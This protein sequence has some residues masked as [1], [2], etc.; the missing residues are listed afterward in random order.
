VCFLDWA[1]CCLQWT[2]ELQSIATGEAAT[3]FLVFKECE[4]NTLNVLYGCVSSETAAT[5]L[6]STISSCFA[7]EVSSSEA[8]VKR[9]A[10]NWPRVL[11]FARRACD[12][13]K[14]ADVKGSERAVLVA[15]L[16]SGLCSP[17]VA[18][19]PQIIVCI[20]TLARFLCGCGRNA[21][22]VDD[23]ERGYREY[24]KWLGQVIAGAS[25]PFVQSLCTC[26]ISL[27]PHEPARY[28]RANEKVLFRAPGLR[29]V[30][31]DYVALARTR[32]F[33]LESS[34][35]TADLAGQATKVVKC[36]AS[37][38]IAEV[39]RFV[40][41]FAIGG[42]V[43]PVSLVRQMNFHRHN[44]R[45]V[46]LEPLLAPDLMPP[47]SFL[48]ELFPK[49]GIL[50]FNQ[51]RIAMIKVMAFER[52]DKAIKR[53]EAEPAI[54]AI[55]LQMEKQVANK[56][57]NYEKNADAG[58]H[59]ALSNESTT[60]ALLQGLW[61]ALDVSSGCGGR[62]LQCAAY[63][64]DS[65][66]ISSIL[67]S[68]F[69]S[70]GRAESE[71]MLSV[72][73]ST[74]E[75]VLRVITARSLCRPHNTCYMLQGRVQRC[76]MRHFEQVV[77]WIRVLLL[78]VFC[79][80]RLAR[81]RRAIQH[82]LLVLLC[83]PNRGGSR[84][85][86]AGLGAFVYTLS[87]LQNEAAL[88]DLA[89][90][91]VDVG[92]TK[93][94][95]MADVVACELAVNDAQML[96]QSS[97]YAI[98]FA[99]LVLAEA[100]DADGDGQMF[101]RQK[102]A[103]G[104]ENVAPLSAV[105]CEGD[106]MLY[107]QPSPGDLF[108]SEGRVNRRSRMTCLPSALVNLLRWLLSSTWRLCFRSQ[109]SISSRFGTT[110]IGG[111]NNDDPTELFR[112][113]LSVLQSPLLTC[114]KLNTRV[115]TE[116]DIRAGWGCEHRAFNVF[117]RFSLAKEGCVAS[118]VGDVAA[119][120]AIR[121]GTQNRCDLLDDTMGKSGLLFPGWL[122]LA[123]ASLSRDSSTAS[124]QA[125][126]SL[127][128]IVRAVDGCVVEAGNSNGNATV[129]MMLDIIG[130]LP[131][132]LY[133][134]RS[135]FDSVCEHVAKTLA[136]SVWPCSEG[137]ARTVVNSYLSWAAL[138]TAHGGRREEP[139]LL[140]VA[141]LA[142]H[143][144]SL[145][146][147]PTVK[148]LLQNGDGPD[149]LVGRAK[150]LWTL[151]SAVYGLDN[152][153]LSTQGKS[154]EF[155]LAESLPST[156]DCLERDRVAFAVVLLYMPY[157]VQVPTRALTAGFCSSRLRLLF[158]W[159][160][161]NDSRCDIAAVV[162]LVSFMATVLPLSGAYRQDAYRMLRSERWS[163]I[164]LQE[165]ICARLELC[166]AAACESAC[167]L[168]RGGSDWKTESTAVVNAFG[169]QERHPGLDVLN[170]VSRCRIVSALGLIHDASWSLVVKSRDPSQL[171]EKF[172]EAAVFL[173]QTKRRAFLQTAASTDKSSSDSTLSTLLPSLEAGID[174]AF[175]R[176]LRH[177]ACDLTQIDPDL[178][179]LDPVLWRR[180][181]S[182]RPV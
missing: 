177:T 175:S 119:A 44:F 163:M 132:H 94:Q 67:A 155:D 140:V 83:L 164:I 96:R 73:D 42:N 127:S 148:K 3:E 153:L 38:A 26:L 146:K 86:G 100:Q 76:G 92:T 40:A 158:K 136:P 77:P 45:S 60:L 24:E 93:M 150:D 41:E 9:D 87:T 78:D 12:A 36:G 21:T 162:D 34:S 104:K 125:D 172:V 176:L 43:I 46:L 145:G 143:W 16:H 17:H 144:A 47:P 142:I 65:K 113:A 112:E 84:N 107:S 103:T 154:C 141:C 114:V 174:V 109:P 157:V 54:S 117:R 59:G 171:L 27:V 102:V 91:L 95:R 28:L 131:G 66:R 58:E 30:V 160:G 169:F 138:D 29:G 81:F 115:W 99:K 68:R 19:E 64:A 122:V 88:F 166:S 124:E 161:E 108:D 123:L 97:Q 89:Y 37:R 85:Y 23:M 71:S 53:A 33:D 151:V 11:L 70:A 69:A 134:G 55:K 48:E 170:P 116:F 135:T 130:H 120:I 156:L 63:Q 105:P 14:W 147:L 31:S 129:G 56:S 52:K 118:V 20:I 179:K 165:T 111:A 133:F 13:K 101:P 25:K 178:S 168:G 61:Y 49:A 75:D 110:G 57:S 32:L 35:E 22:S 82:R 98:A 7:F 173:G 159:L 126:F 80:L 4:E 72:V 149:T 90:V 182:S 6:S 39:A 51:Q 5:L 1:R 50:E 8:A 18:R 74:L 121:C 10:V 137:V 128:P 79:D 180:I 181:E 139:P 2:Y 15:A 106:D 167:L 152:P 62:R